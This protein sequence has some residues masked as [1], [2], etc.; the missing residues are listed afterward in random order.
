[1]AGVTLGLGA[2]RGRA[3]IA[4]RQFVWA[5]GLSAAIIGDED[6]P[7]LTELTARH[8]PASMSSADFP[9][10]AKLFLLDL[11][12]CERLVYFDSDLLYVNRWDPTKLDPNALHVVRDKWWRPAIRADCKR[13]GLP[14]GHYFNSGFLVLNRELHL[15]FL[16]G[17]AN[18]WRRH[19]SPFHD[20]PSLNGE[21]FHRKLRIDWMHRDYNLLARVGTVEAGKFP[22][23]ALHLGGSC[24]EAVFHEVIAKYQGRGTEFAAPEG[25]TM[26]GTWIYERGGKSRRIEFWEDGIIGHGGAQCERFWR[27]WPSDGVPTLTIFGISNAPKKVTETLRAAR[28]GNVWR[29]RWLHSEK[30]EV[31]L[32]PVSTHAVNGGK[33]D[34]L[35]QTM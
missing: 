25:S 14:F 13:W 4:A 32:R 5:T 3:E 10:A 16:H 7:R 31:V 34:R 9:F 29:G 18:S 8:C 22:I 12:D 23:K 28:D 2:Y 30:N 33:I 35:T 20:Q 11:L 27:I 21:A 6:I 24:R 19:R 15:P 1:M 26:A 17:A